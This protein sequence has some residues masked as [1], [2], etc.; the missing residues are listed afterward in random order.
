MES[1]NFALALDLCERTIKSGFN[2][3]QV[4]MIK[5]IALSK[6]E[7]FE[8][9]QTVFTQLLEH[10]PQNSELHYNYALALQENNHKRQALRHYQYCINANKNHS[11]A[12]NNMGVIQLNLKQFS[13]AKMHFEQAL[14]LKPN[15]VE[16]LRNS[17]NASFQLKHYSQ[18]ATIVNSYIHE[19]KG[20]LEEDFILLIDSLY[21]EHELLK[22]QRIYK[23]ALKKFSDSAEIFNLA[24]LIETDCK[25]YYLAHKWIKK[26]LKI[27]ANNVDFLI[28]SIT[29]KAYIKSS[30]FI[31][32][33]LKKLNRKFPANTAVLLFSAKLCESLSK[34]KKSKKFIK[35]G[36]LLE[37][38]RAPFLFILAKIY[39]RKNKI[40]KSLAT[41]KKALKVCKDISLTKEIYFELAKA[42]DKNKK[43]DKAW[44][45][46]ELAN[47]PS[48]NK[49]NS[50]RP[51]DKFVSDIQQ[52]RL[53]F[54]NNFISK[55]LL[56]MDSERETNDIPK[57]VFIVG[58]PRS[59][60]TLLEKI[61]QSNPHVKVLEETHAINELFLKINAQ[62]GSSFSEKLNRLSAIQIDTY[63]KH[64]IDNLTHYIQWQ[65]SDTIVDKMPMNGLQLALINTIFPQAKIVF[66]VRHPL[67]VCLSCLMQ[68]MLQLSSFSSAA[69]AY[70]AFMHLFSS[71]NH[72]LKLN[73][74]SLKYENLISNM[75]LEI[76]N[77]LKFIGLD[78]H[79]NMHHYYKNND[80]VNTPSYQQVAQ[81]IYQS[82]KYRY[83]HYVKHF[84]KEIKPLEKWLEHFN[85]V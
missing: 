80:L 30:S 1:N 71:Y 36:L 67:D 38:N 46:I 21:N 42:Y 3:P 61:L 84:Q 75:P 29:V 25:K 11:S 41:L 59:G 64:Y 83:T 48:E 6:T 15:S 8:Q 74:Y 78:W 53:D 10:F 72:K 12:I 18:C 56:T 23:L 49:R 20:G 82:A 14:K 76:K 69:K 33:S 22:A 68:N 32:K 45:A 9:S 27:E 65:A 5:A 85:Y 50:L 70:D 73:L 81:P 44:K 55:E 79:K 19:K 51:T 39:T 16:Y 28:N 58:F 34:F 77:I 31:L 66:A 47:Q 4:L 2:H 24:A 37:D 57:I 35:Q 40:R 17:A 63:R 7:S 43:Y 60:T 26:A 54:E 62:S 13:A 52:Q